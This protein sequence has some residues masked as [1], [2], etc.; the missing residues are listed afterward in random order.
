MRDGELCSAAFV[1]KMAVVE[2]PSVSHTGS[3]YS[4]EYLPELR[5]RWFILPIHPDCILNEYSGGE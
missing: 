4:Y 5:K 1:T 2:G 3:V